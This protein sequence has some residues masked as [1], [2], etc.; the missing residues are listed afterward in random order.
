[1]CREQSDPIGEKSIF[2]SCTSNKHQRYNYHTDKTQ[3]LPLWGPIAIRNNSLGTDCLVYSP[4]FIPLLAVFTWELRLMEL[5]VG[6]L[7]SR[8]S[9]APACFCVPLSFYFSGNHYLCAGILP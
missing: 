6:G 8:D 5:V 3:H 2:F 4:S 9:L 7:L 1:M